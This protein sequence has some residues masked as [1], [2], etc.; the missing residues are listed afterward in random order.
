VP[1][2]TTATVLCLIRQREGALPVVP[3]REA[4]RAPRLACTPSKD[5]P[6]CESGPCYGSRSCRPDASGTCGRRCADADTGH[7]S[8]PTDNL[9]RVDAVARLDGDVPLVRSRVVSTRSTAPMSPP[10]SPMADATRPSIPGRLAICRANDEAVARARAITPS[11][12]RLSGGPREAVESLRTAAPGAS[13]FVGTLRRELIEGSPV[14]PESL[15]E[16]E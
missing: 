11:I 15:G 1:S 4:K 6:G 12:L 8:Q 5:R 7:A 13:R 2:V 3:D 16:R 10:A 14:K 9:L